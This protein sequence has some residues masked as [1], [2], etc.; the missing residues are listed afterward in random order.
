MHSQD[1][2]GGLAGRAVMAKNLKI[3]SRI[4]ELHRPSDF[5]Y[6]EV[7]TS[8]HFPVAKKVLSDF[9]SQNNTMYGSSSSS[10]K[11]PTRRRSKML[12]NVWNSAPGINQLQIRDET[13]ES[14]KLV[15]ALAEILLSPYHI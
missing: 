7:H 2:G 14:E 4:I 9:Q 13:L 15:N 5:V 6:N 3:I 8:K 12:T 11:N 10:P 1:S